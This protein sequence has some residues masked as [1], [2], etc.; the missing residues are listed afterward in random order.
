MRSLGEPLCESEGMEFVHAE[1]H[2]ER[3][4]NTLRLYIDRP[5]GVTLDDCANISRQLGDLLDVYLEDSAGYNLEVSSPGPERP[6][7]RPAD[8]E[9]FK[10][11][12][13]KL[14]IRKPSEETGAVSPPKAKSV[15]GILLGTSEEVV[16]LMVGDKTVAVPF[17]EIARARLVTIHNGENRC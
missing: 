14:K 10:G 11:K 3:G 5:G 16:E 9:K 2:A 12:M 8:F 17:R 7:G 6:L 1:Y 13:A 4:G 15:T